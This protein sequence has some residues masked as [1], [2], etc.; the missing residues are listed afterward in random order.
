MMKELETERLVL[1]PFI[2]SD[3]DD[4]YEYCRM[5]TVGPNAGWAVHQNKEHSQN[6]LNGFIEKGDVLAVCLKNNG[7]V[8]G[9][10]GLHEKETET[11]DKHYEI[12]YVLST[13]YEGQGY[14]T[15]AVKKVLENAFLERNIPE[16]FVCHFVE[17]R[18]SRRVVEKCGFEYLRYIEYQTLNY[19]K[20][21]SKFYHLTKDE[22]IKQMEEKK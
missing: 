21:L 10:V 13:P 4:F 19:G 11:G 6:I 5:E 17:N 14:M 7:K 16:I 2:S 15:E 12:G 22:F 8:I 9:S 3:L 1:R 20:R 18:K